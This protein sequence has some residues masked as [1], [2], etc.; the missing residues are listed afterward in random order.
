VRGRQGAE[1][2][3]EG[4]RE[5]DDVVRRQC[6]FNIVSISVVPVLLVGVRV[7]ACM[8]VYLCVCACV[9]P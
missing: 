8:P 2:E 4:G 3:G 9:C 5:G 6:V 7:C 1:G